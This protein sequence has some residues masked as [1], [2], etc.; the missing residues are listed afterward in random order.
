MI[1][2]AFRNARILIIDDEASNVEVLRRIL[3]RA[4]FSRI[5]STTDSREAKALYVRHRPDLILLDLRMPNLDGFGVMAELA[6]IAEA[7]YLPILIDSA[8][9]DSGQTTGGDAV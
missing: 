1:S 3:T 8:A 5:E 9:G 4:G 7:S 2:R 6:E